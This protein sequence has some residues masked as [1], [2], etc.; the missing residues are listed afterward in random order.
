[1]KGFD[2]NLLYDLDSKSFLSKIFSNDTS[3]KK[4]KVLLDEGK[5]DFKNSIFDI[6]LSILLNSK[7]PLILKAKYL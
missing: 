1:M 4:N 6:D 2:I 7:L 5:I 3:I